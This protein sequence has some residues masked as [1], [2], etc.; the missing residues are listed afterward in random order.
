MLYPVVRVTNQPTPVYAND[1]KTT[2]LMLAKG[3][4][5]HI[6]AKLTHGKAILGK[7]PG[8]WVLL[9][10]ERAEYVGENC[11]VCFDSTEKLFDSSPATK[12]PCCQHQIHDQCME[13]MVKAGHSGKTIGFNHLK[14]PSCR[15]NLI[16]PFR[17]VW[18]GNIYRIMDEARHLFKQIERMEEAQNQGLPLEEQGNWAFFKCVECKHP[19]CGGKVSCAEE[20]DLDPSTMVCGGCEWGKE[21]EDHRCFEH[22]KDYAIFKC[23]FCCS[24]ASWACGSQH[25]CIYC[26]DHGGYQ[27]PT[28]CPGPSKCPLGMPHPPPIT[29]QERSHYVLS[30]VIGCSKCNN[31]DAEIEY[32]SYNADPFLE[33]PSEKH[34]NLVVKFQYSKF[35]WNKAVDLGGGHLFDTES[36]SEDEIGEHDLEEKLIENN[37][38]VNGVKDSSEGDNAPIEKRDNDILLHAPIFPPL[39]VAQSS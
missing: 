5:L 39:M 16:D 34:A 36:D 12:L 6:T 13:G 10:D 4:N 28:P 38:E 2:R 17:N 25:Y 27:H 32:K 33:N 31:P 11:I 18:R 3:T 24:P 35:H 9:R 22:G 30:F 15:T 29:T 19:F 1:R 21:A 20:F 8:G 26:H 14:C 37:F 23:D 7:T